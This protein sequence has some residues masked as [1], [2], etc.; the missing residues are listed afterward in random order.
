MTVLQSRPA[1]RWL[2]PLAFLL[3]IAGTGLV[4]ANANAGGHLP[5]RTAEQLLVDVSNM[6]T[7]AVSG[8][9]VERANL[10]LPD[11]PGVGSGGSSDLQSLLSGSHTLRVWYSGPDKA[12]VAV[13]GRLGESDIIL[14]GRDLWTWSSQDKTATHRVLT[15]RQATQEKQGSTDLPKTPT[16]AAREALAA[17]TPTTQVNTDS[18]VTVAGRSAYELVLR[19][20]DSRSLVTAVRIAVDGTT[21]LPLRVRAYAAGASPVFEVGYTSIS[22]SR[23][24]AAQFSFNAPPG[25]K[26]TQA[27]TPS[28]P[29]TKAGQA[30]PDH[31]KA[32]QATSSTKV[33]GSG[34]TSVLVAKVPAGSTSS[35]GGSLG[36]V[37]NRLPRVSGTWGSGRLLAGTAFTAVLTDDGRVAVG[38]VKPE[39]LY[40]A[41]R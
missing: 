23:P 36:A 35:A 24:D 40:A 21:H 3:V 11:L 5:P 16:E 9:V 7:D 29:K 26:V 15:A 12:R 27:Q 4:A 8:T 20:K 1:L 17:V 2:A 31:H 41:L 28:E 14:N 10:G 13:Q 32:T 39:L 22:F 6:K 30:R 18:N 33:V 34:W 25:T 38:L 19:P 37:L